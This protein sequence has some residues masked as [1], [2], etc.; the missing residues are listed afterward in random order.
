MWLLY[1]VSGAAFK[2]F[3]SLLQKR[4]SN[5]INPWVYAWIIATITLPMA[6]AVTLIGDHNPI[7]ALQSHW[8]AGAATALTWN[9]ASIFGLMALKREQL[10]Y[11]VPLTAFIPIFS[12]IAG[13]VGIGEQVSLVGLAGVC[14][15]FVGSYVINIEPGQVRWYD[16][17]LRVFKSSGARLSIAGVFLLAVSNVITKGALNDGVS[18]A[19]WL[20]VVSVFSWVGLLHIPLLYPQLVVKAARE[21]YRLLLGLGAVIIGSGLLAILAVSGT[22]TSYA[23]SVRRMD[24]IFSVLLGWR[25][26]KETNIRNKLVGSAFMIAGIAIITAA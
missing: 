24:I 20:F 10:S 8:V 14:S 18:S 26:L 6:A 3:A 16:P 13:W 4:I 22:V 9:A 12:M 25:L 7:G 11:I 15:V 19:E 23:L 2:A 1:G 21:H 17:L 5:K